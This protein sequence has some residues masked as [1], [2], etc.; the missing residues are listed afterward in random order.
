MIELELFSSVLVVSPN[1]PRGRDCSGKPEEREQSCVAGPAFA[2][3]Q[4]WNGKPAC[5]PA[6]ADRPGGPD[7]KRVSLCASGP[8][9]QDSKGNYFSPLMISALES[10]KTFPSGYF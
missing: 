2:G 9:A 10:I 3:R 4:A 5:A 8:A 1:T 7:S 6:S